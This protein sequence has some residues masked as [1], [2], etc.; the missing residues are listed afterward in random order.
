MFFVIDLNFIS[1]RD[2]LMKDFEAL[3]TSQFPSK[4]GQ[5][6]KDEN[7]WFHHHPSLQ[8]PAHSFPDFTFRTYAPV[9]FR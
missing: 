2:L 7:N 3:E 6:V 5:Q 4:G 1:A 9:A 8:T